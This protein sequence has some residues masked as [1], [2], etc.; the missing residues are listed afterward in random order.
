MCLRLLNLGIVFTLSATPPGRMVLTT[1]PV[2]RPPMIPKANPEP[3][4]IKSI[5]STWAHSVFSW[6]AHFV[7]ENGGPIEGVRVAY[8]HFV[9]R[10]QLIRHFHSLL[11]S[12][13]D[14]FPASIWMV[15]VKGWR[16][17]AP[18]KPSTILIVAE[19]LWVL[20]LQ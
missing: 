12:R 20:E 11:S 13:I 9:D 7:L 19:C 14:A 4:L 5:T 16:A 1:T 15:I 6:N 10:L 8:H 18:A 3:S 17:G 2:L